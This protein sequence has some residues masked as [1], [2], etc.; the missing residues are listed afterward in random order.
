[1]SRVADEKV[2]VLDFGSQ[3][4]QLIA[5]RVRGAARLLRNRAARHY[6]RPH[7]RD[8]AQGADPLRRAGQRVRS[9]GAAAATR[10]SSGSACPSW[11]SATACNWPARPPAARSATCRPREYGRARCRVTPAGRV[12]RRRPRRDRRLDEPRRPGLGAVGRVPAAGGHGHLPGRR[13]ETPDSCRSTACSFI[14]RSPTRPRG[15]RSSAIFC[16]RSAAARGTWRLG[17]FAR[18]TVEAV[19]RRVGDRPGDLRA[20]RRRRFVGRR[21]AAGRGHRPAG[22]LHP[23]R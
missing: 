19:R 16:K 11:A 3:Y 2:L 7:P 12:V 10:K 6:G 5:R 4:A 18:E 20:F 9:R 14:P 22:F 17:D 13:G 21:R 15:R 1:M 8:P 23:G